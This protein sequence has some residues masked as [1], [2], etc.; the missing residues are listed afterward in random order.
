MKVGFLFNHD[1]LH[2][3]RHT[4]PV[5]AE[6]ARFPGVEAV[7]LTSSAAQ[8]QQVRALLGSVVANVSFLSLQVG[9]LAAALDRALRFVAP[10][11]RLATLRENLA[12]FATLD[13]L[14]V[15][16]TTSL[17]LRDRFGLVGPKFVWIPHGAGD[18][19]VGFRPVMRGFDLVLLSGLKVQERMLAAGLITA[20]NHAIVGYPKFDTIAPSPPARLFQDD[21]PTVLYNPHFDPKLSSWYTMGEGVLASFA[22]QSRFNLIVAPHVMLAK[23]RIHASV[24]HCVVRWRRDFAARYAGLPHIHIDMGSEA[25]VDM[26]YTRAAD[27][28]LGDASSQVYEWIHRPRPVIHLNA[29][30]F[31]WEN[32]L[33]FAHWRLGDVV[34]DL[35]DLPAALDRAVATPARYRGVQEAAFAAT[36]SVTDQPASRRAAT[37]IMGRFAKA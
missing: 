6:M 27:I 36:F 5:I 24:E 23:R 19:S 29:A 37:S 2:Q 25:S 30:R 35:A 31:A 33:A 34:A 17:L 32:D 15:P 22:A 1:A 13:V 7:V 26:T 20:E 18:R 3:I 11:R 4:A 12:M 8:E 16:E 9:P 14:V 28:Y 21:R 10:F